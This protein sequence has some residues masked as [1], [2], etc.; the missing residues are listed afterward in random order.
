MLRYENFAIGTDKEFEVV[1]AASCCLEGITMRVTDVAGNVAE[2]EAWNGK[3]GTPMSK[4]LLYG[5]IGGGIALVIVIIVVVVACCC[6]KRY[7][8]VS[9]D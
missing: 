2:V 5:L 9:T 3:T 7:T 4:S 6:K 1:A 8:A